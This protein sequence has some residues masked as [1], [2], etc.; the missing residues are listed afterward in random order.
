MYLLCSGPE[1]TPG[2]HLA[3]KRGPWTCAS[4]GEG[5]AE[6]W[7][8]RRAAHGEPRP[9]HDSVTQSNSAFRSCESSRLDSQKL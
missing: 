1:W 9:L 6:K 3:F 5:R 8:R 7:V 4:A 2:I